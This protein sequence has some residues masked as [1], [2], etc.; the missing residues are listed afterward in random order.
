MNKQEI[1]ISSKKI[2]FYT[3]SI[4]FLLITAGLINA[5]YFLYKNFYLSI[6]RSEEI[7]FLRKKVAIQ[8]IDIRKFDEIIKNISAKEKLNE[9]EFANN[10][11]YK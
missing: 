7:I 10:P 9:K 6:N 5:S 4:I 8:S 2:I 11:F 1:K 3:Y